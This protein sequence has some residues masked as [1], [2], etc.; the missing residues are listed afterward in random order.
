MAATQITTRQIVNNAITTA[1]LAANAVTLA[2]LGIFSAKGDLVTYDG[3]AHQ[4]LGVGADGTVLTADSTQANGIKW[5]AAGGGGLTAAN[6]IFGETPAGTVNGTNPTFTL[7][8]TPTSGTVRLYVNGIRQ[9]NGSSN[10]WTI[11]GGTI[12]F[13][14]ASIPL[15]GDVILADYLH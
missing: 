8:N 7:A 10:D 13:V 11:S 15:T 1:K 5:A 9:N 12:T 6:F 14:T 2:I 3:A 4:R